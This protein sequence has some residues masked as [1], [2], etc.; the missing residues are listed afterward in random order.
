MLKIQQARSVYSTLIWALLFIISTCAC[1]YTIGKN[2]SDYLNYDVITQTKSI[3]ENTAIFPA[4]VF[5]AENSSL[6]LK[7]TI[8]HL[9]YSD[10]IYSDFTKPEILE[11][12]IAENFDIL[13]VGDKNCLRFNG[14]SSKETELKKTNGTNPSKG[15]VI[16]FFM[17]NDLEVVLAYVVD[18]YLN[19][20]NNSRSFYLFANN[21]F[22]VKN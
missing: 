15:L 22:L 3:K 14:M 12:N 4:M 20:L 16:G 18:N 11:K 17:P 8:K 9:A 13:N 10:I 19:Y 5:C 2:T 6:S 21:F 1:F 7:D